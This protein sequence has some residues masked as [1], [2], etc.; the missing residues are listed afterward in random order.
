MPGVQ[1]TPVRKLEWDTAGRTCGRLVNVLCAH[2]IPL[3]RR[4]WR[5]TPCDGS[6]QR[7]AQCSGG[8]R[9]SCQ[10]HCTDFFILRSMTDAQCWAPLAFAFVLRIRAAGVGERWLISL[11]GAAPRETAPSPCKIADSRDLWSEASSLLVLFFFFF[12]YLLSLV[13]FVFSF[14]NWFQSS[15]IHQAFRL[16]STGKYS[17]RGWPCRPAKGRSLI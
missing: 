7:P 6:Q 3:K 16:H 13:A 9:V 4:F 5:K 12:K 10:C 11:A 1:R 17:C 15:S 2:G 14:Y 8:K